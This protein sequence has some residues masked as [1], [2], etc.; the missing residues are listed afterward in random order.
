MTDP[1]PPAAPRVVAPSAVTPVAGTPRAAAPSAGTPRAV[2]PSAVSPS[3]GRG[4]ASSGA[5]SSKLSPALA[6]LGFRY[7]SPKAV[8]DGSAAGNGAPGLTSGISAPGVTSGVGA[9]GVT[10]GYERRVPAGR[11]SSD[12]ASVAGRG[13][14]VPKSKLLGQVRLAIRARHMSPRTERQYVHWVKRFVLFHGKRHPLELG[15]EEVTA[16]LNHLA[17]RAKVSASTQTQALSA[18]LFMY[19]RVLR[20]QLPWLKGIVRAKRAQHIPVVLTRDEV[21]ALLAALD[22][23]P[24]LVAML[25]Y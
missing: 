25:L 16:F 9:P 15:E 4:S 18:L 22:G 7:L 20:R 11:W 1:H 13:R 21:R 23:V 19:R 14:V 3:A 8:A 12:G 5:D 2:A 17:D 24:R 6:A 10:A